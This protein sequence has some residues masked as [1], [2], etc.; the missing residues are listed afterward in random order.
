MGV[1]VNGS[2]YPSEVV[3]I[4]T[5]AEK[6]AKR[7]KEQAEQNYQY[8]IQASQNQMDTFIDPVD[9]ITKTMKGFGDLLSINRSIKAIDKAAK[10]KKQ[11]ATNAELK[12]LAFSPQD[13]DVVEAV[14]RYKNDEKNINATHGDFLKFLATQGNISPQ[15]KQYLTEL[16]AGE[17]LRAAKWIGTHSIA[18]SYQDFT[19]NHIISAYGKTPAES[20]LKFDSTIGNDPDKVRKAFNDFSVER[21][22]KLGL[23]KDLITHNY[24]DSI[25]EIASTLSGT[26]AS[27]YKVENLTKIGL[28][29]ANNIDAA[30]DELQRNENALTQVVHETILKLSKPVTE[31]GKGLDTTEATRQVT[32]MLV[33]QVLNKRLSY[34]E[35]TDIK[36]GLNLGNNPAGK[37][38]EVMLSKE[39]F[40]LIDKAYTDMAANE[41][42]L[43]TAQRTKEANIAISELNSG[44]RDAEG[45]DR[46]LARHI[47]LGGKDTDALYIQ[48]Q[49][50]D[51][52]YQTKN[53]YEQEKPRIEALLSDGTTKVADLTIRNN[54]L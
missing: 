9:T 45:R 31:G 3:D 8:Q 10:D 6:A 17:L 39:Q 16:S 38:G 30:Q 36:R 35:F 51:P 28:D 41:V 12:R 26:A 27:L 11:E 42:K 43:Q 19:E 5:P 47:A 48:I 29:F 24:L 18:T 20:R 32:S 54:Q 50:T 37:T 21:L 4:L 46:A 7:A 1:I 53:V 44:I 14:V 40:A 34:A 2:Y 33:M 52:N 49:N 22:R 23:S 13:K 15:L 25:H